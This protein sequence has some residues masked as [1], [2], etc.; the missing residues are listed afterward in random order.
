MLNRYGREYGVRVPFQNAKQ[1]GV[2]MSNEG[3]TL[4]SAGWSTQHLRTI[5]GQRW[6]RWIWTDDDITRTDAQAANAAT[7]QTAPEAQS[8]NDFGGGGGMFD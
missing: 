5:H 3:E 2:R 8:F 1:L 7:R 6:S 4:R